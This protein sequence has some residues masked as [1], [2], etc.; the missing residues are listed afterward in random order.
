MRDVAYHLHHLVLQ[1]LGWD[2]G[3]LPAQGI[4]NRDEHLFPA[5]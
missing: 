4:E 1:Q 5:L 2:V 3:S